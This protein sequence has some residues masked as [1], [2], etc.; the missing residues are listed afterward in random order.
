MTAETNRIDLKIGDLALSVQGADDPV[1]TVKQVLRFVQR[2][3]E[4]TPEM[5]G[6]GVTLEEAEV[7]AMLADLEA[8]GGVPEGH[9]TVTPGLI[10]TAGM[11][12]AASA[13]ESA[14][15]APVADDGDAIA[16]P[17]PGGTDAPAS[18]GPA[19]FDDPD[20]DAPL[21]ASLAEDDPAHAEPETAAYDA[22]PADEAGTRDEDRL[23]DGPDAAADGAG[24]GSR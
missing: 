15:A 5:T 6:A 7:T 13:S 11:P 10:L 14:A 21:A 17:G 18:A 23:A 2:L 4:E 24:T 9:F 19:L 8:G 1:R 16:M 22:P 3:V 12:A 20:S